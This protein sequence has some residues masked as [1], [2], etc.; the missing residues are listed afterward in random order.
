MLERRYEKRDGW[1]E[2]E[3]HEDLEGD[4]ESWRLMMEEG[5][6]ERVSDLRMKKKKTD[7]EGQR[8]FE[9]LL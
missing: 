3:R 4:G 1:E 9:L 8:F 5:G 6:V 2:R 7:L